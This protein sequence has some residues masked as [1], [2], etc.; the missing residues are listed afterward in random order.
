MQVP[1]SVPSIFIS[2][3]DAMDHSIMKIVRHMHI[4]VSDFTILQNLIF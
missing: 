2:H 4:K 3:M 1:H